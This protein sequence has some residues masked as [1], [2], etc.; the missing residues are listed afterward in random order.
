MTRFTVF[1]HQFFVDF[2]GVYKIEIDNDEMDIIFKDKKPS[3]F[4]H[5]EAIKNP[6]TPYERRVIIKKSRNTKDIFETYY[7]RRFHNIP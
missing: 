6:E 2:D 7:L 3:F 5:H 4:C 1:H